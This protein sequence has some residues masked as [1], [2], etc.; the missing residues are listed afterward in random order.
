MRD[1]LYFNPDSEIPDADLLGI[2]DL[3]YSDGSTQYVQDPE[4]VAGLPPIPPGMVPGGVVGSRQPSTQPMGPPEMPPPVELDSPQGPVQMDMT[5]NISPLTRGLNALGNTL[6][7]APGADSSQPGLGN[8]LGDAASSFATTMGG[9]MAPQTPEAP[10]QPPPVTIQSERGP[11]TIDPTGNI[12]QGAG[13]VPLEQLQQQAAGGGGMVPVQRE[14][15]LPPDVAAQQMS[16]M[17]AMNAQT[18]AATQQARSEEARLYNELTL[19]QMA[20]N[21]AER[22]KREQELAD[23]QARAERLIQETQAVNDVQIDQS[24]TEARGDLGGFFMVLGAVAQG[25]AGNDAGF[26]MIDRQVDRWVNDQV[27]RKDTKLALLAN[28]LGSTQQAIAAG[29]A[30]LYKVGADR[31]ELLAQ[32]T[33]NDVFEAQTPAMIQALRQKQME[34]SQKFQRDSLGKTLEK[35]PLPPKPPSEEMLLKYGQ[36][37]RDRDAGINIGQRVEQQLGLIWEPGREGQPGRYRNKDEIL[38]N[39][40]QGI[41]NLEQ[42]LPDA[43]YS[44]LGGMT[45]EGYQ[46]RGAAEAMAYATIRQMQ[47]VGPISNA[48]IKAAVK[49]GALDTEQGMLAA[50]ERI[51]AGAEEQQQ[52]DSAQFG[53]NV[54]AEYE[55]RRQA[56]G[57]APLGQSPAGS[58]PATLQDLKGAGARP[59]TTGP[60][61]RGPGNLP[62]PTPEEFKA[63]VQGFA[64]S[65]GLNPQAV[66]AVINHESGG[67][68]GVTNKQTGKHAG[69]IQFSQETWESLAREAGTPDLS[70]EEMRKMSAEEQLPYVMM[71]YNR[72]GLGPDNDAGDYAM[73]TFMPA[74]WNKPDDFVLGLKDS[75]EKIGGLSMGKVW[76]QNPGL[77][78]GNTITVGDV[79]RSVGG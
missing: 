69:L 40:I 45:A 7:G 57:G 59:E 49:A 1:L 76:A 52:S 34:E 44:T 63:S 73:A 25:A 46:V 31:M 70:W 23:N 14:G 17:G 33:K 15:A 26:R 61:A 75:T 42:W 72:L 78:N 67:K 65:A 77:R 38:A 35:A 20:A 9:G 39:G 11:V 2:G 22:V 74:Y 48:D 66:L 27:R 8:M 54:V 13:G 5:G 58:R 10:K 24:I 71:Y 37:R 36:L 6:A 60:E 28:Q 43:V 56:S 29:K 79:R 32:K 3:I 64:E 19:K 41:G 53:P 30:A 12:Q 51:R 62:P 4:L 47:P 50:L 21:E 55:R 68:P 18:L 16:Q